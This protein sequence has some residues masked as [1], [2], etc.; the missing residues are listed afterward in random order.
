MLL[1][2]IIIL[3]IGFL[4]YVSLTTAQS[5]DRAKEVGVRK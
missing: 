1:I 5:L 3:L 4:N 2:A